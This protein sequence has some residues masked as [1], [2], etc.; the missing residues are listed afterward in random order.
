MGMW[1]DIG[2]KMGKKWDKWELGLLAASLGF[3]LFFAFYDGPVWC[4]DSLSYATMDLTREPLYPT[5]LWIFRRMFGEESY[6]IIKEKHCRHQADR[7]QHLLPQIHQQ[8]RKKYRPCQISF[9][10]LHHIPVQLHDKKNIQR[11]PKPFRHN[12]ANIG[13]T[14]GR[15]KS[16]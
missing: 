12:T 10:L 14:S 9:F 16:T 1:T 15:Y 5:F 4:K 11:Q 6:L 3:Y 7:N 13:R 2:K 8:Q